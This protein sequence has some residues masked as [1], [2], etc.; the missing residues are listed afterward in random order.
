MSVNNWDLAEQY[1]A[2]RF[3]NSHG[4]VEVIL[5]FR[6]SENVVPLTGNIHSCIEMLKRNA[7]ATTATRSKLY[8]EVEKLKKK[9]VKLLAYNEQPHHHPD[10]RIKLDLS[11]CAKVNYGKFSDLLAEVNAV[12]GGRADE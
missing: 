5:G 3:D 4:R 9:H 7:A 10:M 8:K 2:A 12:T 6:F 11:D 1:H